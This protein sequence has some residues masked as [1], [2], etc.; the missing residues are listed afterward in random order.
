MFILVEMK[1]VRLRSN[2][3]KILFQILMSVKREFQVTKIR[4][5]IS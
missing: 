1:M 5:L 2:V 3:L 4:V